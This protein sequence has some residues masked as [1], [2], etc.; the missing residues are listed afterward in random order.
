MFFFH[1]FFSI[2]I[3]IIIIQVLDLGSSI[4][5]IC[6]GR[7]HTMC[8]SSQTGSIYSFGLN[9]MGQLGV[10]TYT[11]HNSPVRIKQFWRVFS[12]H[13]DLMNVPSDD[14]K[15]YFQH[16]FDE[17]VVASAEWKQSTSSGAGN[18]NSDILVGLAAGGLSSF[19]LTC[20]I[21]VVFAIHLFCLL[22]TSPSPR[23]S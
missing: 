15:L 22:Y 6:C 18:S 4:T 3:F 5:N 7:K 10:G 2:F 12:P 11:K 13:T 21:E 8:Y 1:I 23:D 14:K 16:Q 17:F 19:L 9:V 20:P